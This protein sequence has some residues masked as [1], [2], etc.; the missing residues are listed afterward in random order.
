ML[1][2]T[3]RPRGDMFSEL[4]RLQGLLDQVFRPSG[5]ASIRA[6]AGESFPVINL[7]S[8]PDTVEVM[9]LAPGLDPAKIELSIERG[10]LTIA[11]ERV[12]VASASGTESR[13]GSTVYAQERFHGRFRRVVSLPDDVD[14]A[15]VDATY[16]DGILWITLHKRESAKPRQIQIN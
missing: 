2:T 3:S 6:L 13:P 11:G 5:R 8:T 15:R 12:A 9:A 14:S 1:Y 10:V 7:G 4:D 16:R